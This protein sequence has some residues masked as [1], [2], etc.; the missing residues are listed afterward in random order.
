MILTFDASIDGAVIRA[1]IGSDRDLT[2]P[3]WCFSLMAPGRVVAGG[4]W[5]T[6][7]GGYCEVRLPDLRAG[8]V[9]AVTIAHANPDFRPVNR[10]WLPLGGYLRLAD[11]SCHA[12]PDLPAGVAPCRDRT[13]PEPSGLRLIPPPADW[14]PGEGTLAAR[15][16]AVSGEPFAAA[17]G[18]SR[19]LGFGPFIDATGVKIDVHHDPS[20]PDEAQVIEIG[21]QGIRLS[22]SGRGGLFHGAVTLMTLAQTHQGALPCG[23]ITDRPRFGWRGQ[24]LDCARHFFRTGTITRLMDLMALLK[25]NRFHWHFADDEAFRLEIDGAPD[26]WRKTA[27]R[28]EGELVPGVFGGGIRAGG[29]YS[30]AEV[31]ALIDHAAALNIQILPEVEVPA[32]A[33]ALNRAIPGLRD[34]RDSGSECSV[35]GYPENAVNPAMPA[36][37]DFLTPLLAEVAA[38]FPMG[39]LH[40]GCDEL[41]PGTWDGSPAAAVLKQR[42]GLGNRDD[43]QGW[44]MARLAADLAARGIRSAAWEEA[45]RGAQGGIGH[46]ALMFS[47]TGQGPGIAAARMGH[48][49]VMCPAQHAYLDMAHTGDPGDWGAAWA[50]FV[51][52]EDTVDW[53]VVPE[54]AAD[55]APRIAGVQG[56]FWSEFT[57]ADRQM[58]AMLA[59]RILGIAA[60]AWGAEGAVDGAGLRALAGAYAPLFDRMGWE[61]HRG[62]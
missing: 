39:M 45:A 27:W 21:A 5:L 12:L 29:S 52:L 61:R 33:L 10:A 4:E 17:D 38:I 44:M 9:H 2:A 40:L 25:L 57:T 18:L 62:A 1:E 36:T 6:G 15:G 16:F 11:G 30:R 7:L 55:I 28:G 51:S 58:E 43:L 24:H 8:Q 31:A 54:G 13:A 42:E 20:L 41:A 49:V 23:T 50:A 46:G 37:F 22:A 59:P 53:Q 35:Q 47:W 48:D 34:P 60:K 3:V 56:C 32:H 26:L 14:A 19:R